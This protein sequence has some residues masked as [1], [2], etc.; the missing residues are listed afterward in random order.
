MGFYDFNRMLM[1]LLLFGVNR[2]IDTTY[3]AAVVIPK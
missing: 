1:T 2:L 3:I